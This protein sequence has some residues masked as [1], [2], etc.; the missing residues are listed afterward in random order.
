MV[1][2]RDLSIKKK[3]QYLLVSIAAAA[4]M[5]ATSV[6]LTN[7]AY[8][9]RRSLVEDL[10]T[11]AD[12]I[13]TN[14]AAALIFEDAPSAEK[15]L[16][17]LRL[18]PDVVAARIYKDGKVLAELTGANQGKSELLFPT[19]F[20]DGEAPK[21]GK[22]NEKS[23]YFHGDYLT[24]TKPIR[25]DNEIVG[26]IHLVATLDRLYL[27]LK[28][29]ALIAL[30]VML[31]AVT[32]A[33]GLSFRL[34]RVISDPIKALVG[35][36]TR[37]RER[38]DYS[39]RIDTRS[40]DELGSL[41]D[42]F[43]EM[44]TQVHERD[45]ALAMHGEQLER[46]VEE[47]TAELAR[48]NANLQRAV[49]E[50]VR[51]KEA[52]ESA[53]RAKS[54][55]LARMS[56]EIRTPMNGVLGMTELLSNTELTP[57]QE[58][59]TVT[60][61]RSAES[62]LGI[63]NDIL[64]FSKIEAGKLE[65][66]RVVFNLR[67]VVEDVAELFSETAHQ[68]GLELVCAVSP[69]LPKFWSG[70]PGRLRQILLN[71][72]SNAL[73]F[74]DEGQVVVQVGLIELSGETGLIRVA[75]QDTGI[76]VA[77]ETLTRIFDA[78]SQADGSMTR[79][80]GGTGL[81]LTIA[82]QLAAL[83]GGELGV[84]AGVPNGSV[85]WFT[86]R[87]QKEPEDRSG[88]LANQQLLEHLNALIVDDNDTNREILEHQLRAWKVNT[89]SAA[90]GQKALEMLRSASDQGRSYQLAILDMHMPEMDG[91]ELARRIRSDTAIAATR[92]VML[93]SAADMGSSEGRAPL[94]IEAY[95]TKP[96]RQ[97]ELYNCLAAVVGRAAT[98]LSVRR[99]PATA[100]RSV[101]LLESHILLAE[102]NT[103][104]Q[105]VALG[106]LEALGCTV[107]LVENGHEVIE[108]LS[109]RAY[110][111][112]LMDCHMPEMDGFQATAEI[113][114]QEHQARRDERIPIVALTANALQGDRAR[115]L[116]AG[117][118][119]YLSKPFTQAQLRGVLTRWLRPD[120][121]FEQRI[122]AARIVEPATIAPSATPA[123]GAVLDENAL[124]RIRA[125]QRPGRP[126]VLNKVVR[127][128]LDDSP[129]LIEALQAAVRQGDA[130]ALQKAAHTLK[131]SSANLGAMV[132]SDLCK[133]LE[134]LG[135]A[136]DLEKAPTLMSQVEHN[137]PVVRQALAAR[138]A[139][140]IT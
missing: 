88:A 35:A 27:R 53:S 115:C 5:V 67:E 77:P 20:A 93:S 62:L 117:M 32:I 43:N 123:A 66:D 135:R 50:S 44:L 83:M 54:E 8:A 106:M 10:A 89:G 124:N 116:A 109:R 108:A 72:V 18:S 94:G 56:H 136:A 119:D 97:S 91:G 78:F 133:E 6:D 71:L 3:L 1:A 2:F 24:L 26:T 126:S 30:G 17:A 139:G 138:L 134:S 61:R 11:L 41:A 15:T 107:K 81:G 33:Y 82:R 121:G 73:K 29:E 49:Q 92:L 13:G 28:T 55:F 7:E 57:K 60:I 14:S 42:G 87:L 74:T 95:L 100:K 103:V 9:F 37:V 12:I 22:T 79:R 132:V 16:S 58:R 75:V 40:Q 63:I 21:V 111:V 34:H 128:Y 101:A 122:E 46:K 114:N 70:D 45:R 104:N 69:D 84:E 48:A 65:L 51:A 105:E 76:G 38:K 129:R 86:V 68:K 125:L 102:D 52:A 99:K 4:L 127:L 23:H 110:D 80:Y 36:M 39:V 85:F 96:W 47:R 120:N 59:F 118:D 140:E 98:R 19:Q 113:R 137:Y 112:I 130:Q 131:S 25:F 90:N 64:D 31:A